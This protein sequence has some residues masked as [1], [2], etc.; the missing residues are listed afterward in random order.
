MQGQ[1]PDHSTIADFVGQHGKALGK[2]FGDTLEV[3]M[4]A[5]LVKLALQ[6]WGSRIA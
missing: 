5:E 1:I 3:L 6:R 4:G 2:L